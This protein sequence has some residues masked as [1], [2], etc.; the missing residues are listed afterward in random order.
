M[1]VPTFPG[2]DAAG[3]DEGFVTTR[4]GMRIHWDR[5]APPRPRSTVL[6]LHGAGDHSGR[7]AGVTAALV[8]EGHEV[9]LLDFRGHGRSEGKRWFVERFEDYLS[10]LDAFAAHARAGAGGRKL[11]VL[12]HSQGGHV[13]AHWA[14]AGGR[15]VDGYV[16]SSPFFQL[17]VPPP[18]VKVWASLLVGKVIPHLPVDAA[19]DLAELTS[20]PEMQRWTDTDP[21]YQRKVTPGWFIAS[22]KAQEALRPRMRE[23]DRPLLLL[24]GTGDR[25]A[26]PEAGRAFASAARSRD[27][28]VVEYPGLKHEILNERVRDQVIADVVD[29]IS[30]RSAPKTH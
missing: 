26:D 23:F 27:K 2:P 1:S 28:Q 18:R 16:L 11:F 19:L 14:L 10:D 12:A 6:V 25:I 3:H 4:D 20:D 5:Y 9:A 13:A 7:Y 30:A 17:A 21:L 22:G 29:W 24:L 8:R 15:D